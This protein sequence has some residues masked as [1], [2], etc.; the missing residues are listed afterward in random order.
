LAKEFYRDEGERVVISDAIVFDRRGGV[1]YLFKPRLTPEDVI[2][3]KFAAVIDEAGVRYAIVAGYIA[4]LFGRARRS[5]DIDFVL[6]YLGEDKFVNLCRKARRAGFTMMQGNIESEESVRDVYR[7]YLV[8]GY[9]VRFMYGDII[10]PNIEAKLATTSVHRYVIFHSIR[11]VVNNEYTLRVSPL[12][13]QIAY[14]LYLGSD[15][16]IG[17]AIFLYTLFKKII[18]LQELHMWCG[19]LGVD[20]GV[21]GGDNW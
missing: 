8:R 17:D 16:D 21:L 18:S 12:E 2:A 19:R 4:I 1:I 10:L 3:S 7:G 6:E 9:S 11:V 5:D 15:K 14:K 20:C 13:L